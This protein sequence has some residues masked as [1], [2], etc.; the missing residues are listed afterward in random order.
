MND[1]INPASHEDMLPIGMLGNGRGT[2]KAME[3]VA[4]RKTNIEG[5]Q[6]FHYEKIS[7]TEFE[8]SGGIPAIIGGAKRWPEPHTTVIVSEEELA[9]ELEAVSE[10][11]P[12]G[13]DDSVRVAAPAVLVSSAVQSLAGIT[14]A[15]LANPASSKQK[16]MTV[17]LRMPDDAAGHQRIADML[18]LD[19]NFFGAVVMA[20]A[21]QED[22]LVSQ[23]LQKS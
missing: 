2:A 15:K 3:T 6:P 9:Q 12:A 23:F 10:E 21:F 18:A 20:T 13:N 8:V 5:W 4:I 19:N 14:D 17:I 16:Y 22:I 1:T 7:A 11:A